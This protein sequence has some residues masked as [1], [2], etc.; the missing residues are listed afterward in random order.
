MQESSNNKIE[1]SR[2]AWPASSINNYT[3]IS[4]GDW[5]YLIIYSDTSTDFIATRP[6]DEEIYERWGYTLNR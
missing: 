3:S 2:E 5:G 4:S 1:I 6:T